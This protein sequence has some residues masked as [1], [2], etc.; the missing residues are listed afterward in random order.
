MERQTN[1]SDFSKLPNG[2]LER[3][4]KKVLENAA[5]KWNSSRNLAEI[6]DYAGANSYAIIS[7]EE[8]IK[9]FVLFLDSRG[10]RFRLVPGMERLF[11]N[12]DSRFFIAYMVSLAPV[13][14]KIVAD[15][16]NE[17]PGIVFSLT[18]TPQMFRQARNGETVTGEIKGPDFNKEHLKDYF[19][20]KRDQV[21]IEGDWFARLE[22]LRQTGFYCDYRD[23]LENPVDVTKEQYREVRKK[24]SQ[25]R[26]VVLE[27][28]D[29]INSGDPENN[30]IIGDLV[31]D[32]EE[33][34]MYK[35]VQEDLKEVRGKDLFQIMNEYF[36]SWDSLK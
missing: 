35:Q 13:L 33:K 5:Q 24:L 26:R 4:Y 16:I 29:L 14:G 17:L 1:Q 9:G 7:T 21:I 22:S 12:H 28:I 20:K 10:F 11:K 34:N 8:L 30:S 27:I 25:V 36:R 15:F 18:L 32:F 6:G 31:R 23:D 2:E 19:R 3:S